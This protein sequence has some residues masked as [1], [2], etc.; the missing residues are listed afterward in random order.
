MGGGLPS[1]STPVWSASTLSGAH[2][3][4]NGFYVVRIMNMDG[5]PNTRNQTRD[6][7]PRHP[8]PYLAMTPPS[9]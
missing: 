8:V 6:N 9:A 3:R 1:M 2:A 4:S 7:H 5:C